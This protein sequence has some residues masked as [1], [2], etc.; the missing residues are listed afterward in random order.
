MARDMTIAAAPPQASA[1]HLMRRLTK[2]YLI[3]YIGLVGMALFFMIVSAAMTATLA[4]LMKPVMDDVLGGNRAMI[5]PVALAVF[6]TFIVQGIATYAHTI[7]MNKVSQS[8]IGDVQKDLFAH[9]MTLDLA[10]FHANPSGQLISRVVNDV[11]VMRLSL[12]ETLTNAGKNFMTFVFLTGVMFHQEWKLAATAFLI[13][14]VSAWF[15]AYIGRRLRKISKNTQMEV[16]ILSDRLSQIFQ[17]IRQVQAYG[18]EAHEKERANKAIEKVRGLSMKANRVGNMLTPVNEALVGM[19]VCGLII[20]G[21]Y[22]VAAGAM[23]QGQLASFL[24]AFGLA[25]EPVKRMARSNNLLQMGLGATERVLQMLDIRPSIVDRDNAKILD[26][27]NPEIIFENVEFYYD[28][29]ESKALRGVSFKASPGKV[30]ALVGKSGAGKSTIINLVPRLYDVKSGRI[31]ING[32]D[33]RDIEL[34]SL[35]R[36]IALVSQDITIFD[37]SVAA[38]IAYGRLDAT[39]DEIVAAAK[40]AAAHDFIEQLI[41]GYDTRV[42]EDGVKLSGG[43]KQRISIARAILRD[44]PILL[45]D[46][47]TSALDN[48]SEKAVQHALRELEKGRTTVVIAHRLSTVQEADQI[49]V[50][51]QGRIVEQG[52]HDDLMAKDGAYTQMYNAGL[53]DSP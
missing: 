30:T 26:A 3:A 52:R 13:L 23:T 2:T 50:M 46:E 45:L 49:I 5:I 43:Q 37:D 47:A 25:Y 24:T 44:A 4:W 40:A 36:N 53:K 12:S 33:V 20:Y 14:P 38:N 22:Q 28:N 35:R 42:G 32:Q 15:I 6:A 48:E 27:R 19:V 41:D 11:N 16:G 34:R 7:I 9:L 1:F 21:G 51:E 8:I 18:T 31:L 10:F 29:M 39:R 17:G